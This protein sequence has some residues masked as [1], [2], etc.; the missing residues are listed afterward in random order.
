MKPLKTTS[1]MAP[2]R[3]IK[4]DLMYKSELQSFECFRRRHLEKCNNSSHLNEFTQQENNNKEQQI[5][6]HPSNN[7]KNN[8]NYTIKNNSNNN[9][10]T[11]SNN[12]GCCSKHNNTDVVDIGNVTSRRR[13]H[14]SSITTSQSRRRCDISSITTSSS[15]SYFCYRRRNHLKQLW[16]YVFIIITIITTLPGKLLLFITS[17]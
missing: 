3:H 11:S 10:I 16:Y 17:I 14:I 5:T 15:N 7:N 6:C 1:K 4:S 13:C 9:F 2:G 12:I 8:N